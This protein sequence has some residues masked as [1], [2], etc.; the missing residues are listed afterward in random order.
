M[1]VSVSQRETHFFD[2]LAYLKKMLF[3]L[4]VFHLYLKK[5]QYSLSR[6]GEAC[7]DKIYA[8]KTLR[9]VSQR[10]VRLRAVLVSTVSESVQC[11]PARSNLFREYRC[12]SQLR[13]FKNLMF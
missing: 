13:I 10:G 11:L 12:V 2:K 5:I 7:K 4:E 8:G 9:S 1:L 6:Q 3:Y